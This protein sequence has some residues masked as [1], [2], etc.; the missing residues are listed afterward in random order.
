MLNNEV[1]KEYIAGKKK[2]K[3][4]HKFKWNN[5][6]FPLSRVPAKHMETLICHVTHLRFLCSPLKPNSKS[7]NHT[8]PL[9]LWNTWYINIHYLI[10]SNP[11][12]M[13]ANEEKQ[14]QSW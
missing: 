7:I 14:S 13:E 11:K 4:T 5:S 10:F 9:G 1:E 8:G 2:K 6:L 12:G 3:Q